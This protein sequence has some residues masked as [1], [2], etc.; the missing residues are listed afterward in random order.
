MRQMAQE[1]P[2]SVLTVTIACASVGSP[3]LPAEECGR[4]AEQRDPCPCEVLV[5]RKGEQQSEN[6]KD[7]SQQGPGQLGSRLTGEDCFHDPA[8]ALWHH[9]MMPGSGAQVGRYDM[10]NRPRRVQA[11]IDRAASA[12]RWTLAAMGF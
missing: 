3:P 10:Q 9:R 8:D 11:A 4:E 6:G 2:A 12:S 1:L 5:V 7:A